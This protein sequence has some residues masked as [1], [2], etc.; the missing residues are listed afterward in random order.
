[1]FFMVSFRHINPVKEHPGRITKTNRRIDSN[2]N[3]EE[4]EFP[5]Q[6][7][8][9]IK[10]IEV[11]NNFCINVFGYENELVYPVFISKHLKIQ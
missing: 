4:I 8:K 7:K 9:K 5:V 2:L 6:K 11:Q 3:Y 10:K 1:M